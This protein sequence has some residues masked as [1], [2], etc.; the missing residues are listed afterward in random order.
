MRNTARPDSLLLHKKACV[1][2]LARLLV[3]SCRSTVACSTGHAAS[4]QTCGLPGIC[5][6]STVCSDMRASSQASDARCP[7]T[8]M[9]HQVRC[10]SFSCRAPPSPKYTPVATYCGWGSA[11]ESQHLQAWVWCLARDTHLLREY[12]SVTCCLSAG[13]AFR[14]TP[15]YP[16]SSSGLDQSRGDIET[17]GGIKH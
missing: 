15:E 9:Q 1:V 11:P 7:G 4:R 12:S 17:K 2:L 3:S 16:Y 14:C 10:C 5:S 13:F 6:G 8:Y